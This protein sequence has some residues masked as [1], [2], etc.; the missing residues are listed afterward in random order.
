MKKKGE[1]VS[2]KHF[3]KTLDKFWAGPLDRCERRLDRVLN[4]ID[5]LA[6]KADRVFRQEQNRGK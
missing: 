2:A 4:E 5:D 1:T 6:S 3:E